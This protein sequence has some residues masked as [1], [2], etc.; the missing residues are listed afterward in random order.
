M[1]EWVGGDVCSY[2]MPKHLL[3]DPHHIAAAAI[4]VAIGMMQLQ[5]TTLNGWHWFELAPF[6]VSLK[7]LK[8]SC[9][10]V[11]PKNCPTSAGHACDWGP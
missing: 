2:Q 1:T 4:W 8:G 11:S 5:P 9:C 10:T 3:Y 7:T 6:Q